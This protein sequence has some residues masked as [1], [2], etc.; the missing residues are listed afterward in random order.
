[1]I[2]VP[3]LAVKKG[4]GI[5]V[6]LEVELKKQGKG[7]LFLD[8]NLYGDNDIRQALDTAFSLLHLKR[9]DVLIRVPGNKDC[10]IC[11]G[12]LALPLYLG[13]YACIN[14]LKFK[15]RTFAT[16]CLSKKGK[17]TPVGSLAEKIKVILGKADLLLVPKGQGLPVERMKI[18]EI[19]SLREAV[20]FAIVK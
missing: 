13:M 9:Q 18:K 3:I 14:G 11:G 19:S 16:G 7:T 17:I 12:S 4:K 10:C 5:I 15:P 1:M 6:E 20:N 2:R 8:A